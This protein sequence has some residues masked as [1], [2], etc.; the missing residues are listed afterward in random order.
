MNRLP[1]TFRLG[2][3]FAWMAALALAFF[4]MN[5]FAQS[6]YPNKPLKIVVGF[7]PG[8]ATDVIARLLAEKLTPVLV[9][10]ILLP[11]LFLV[12]I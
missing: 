10:E 12:L 3:V 9:D 1:L 8:Q 7:P 11:I 6:D 4:A 2:P 5:A